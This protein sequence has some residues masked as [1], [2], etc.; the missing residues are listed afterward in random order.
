MN[1]RLREELID[2]LAVLHEQLCLAHSR[3]ERGWPRC[4][5]ADADGRVMSILH[6]LRE[7][8][9]GEHGGA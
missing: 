4:L 5:V 2:E 9:G 1:D 3:L 7:Q 8:E 6:D